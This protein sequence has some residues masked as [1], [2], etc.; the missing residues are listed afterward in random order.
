M[1]ILNRWPIGAVV[2]VHWTLLAIRN[3]SK[4]RSYEEMNTSGVSNNIYN[5]T[6]HSNSRSYCP[7][8]LQPL[9][10]SLRF[11]SFAAATKARALTFTL[12]R[13]STHSL[14]MAESSI[15]DSHS[16]FLPFLSSQLLC[17]WKCNMGNEIIHLYQHFSQLNEILVTMI[18]SF[19]LLFLFFIRFS[20]W[21]FFFFYLRTS[22]LPLFLFFLTHCQ[23][24]WWDY[25]GYSYPHK[26]YAEIVVVR[27]GETAWNAD[28]R[29]QVFVFPLSF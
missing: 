15:F 3:A 7:P 20:R 10:S 21:D 19:L 4:K 14:K 22:I 1:F 17:I 5:C 16:R 29:I 18:A 6:P 24:N 12:T 27:H 13:H 11:K 25:A 28:G 9:P 26:E 8:P 23:T 2:I